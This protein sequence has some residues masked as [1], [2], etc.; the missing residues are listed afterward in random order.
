MTFHE[1]QFPTDIAFGST[2]GPGFSTDIVTAQSGYEQRNVNWATARASYNV[3]HGVKATAQ[4]TELIA[5]FRAR[6]G[7]AYGFRFKDWADFSV[8]SA[9]IGVGDAVTTQFQLVRSYVSGAQTVVRNVAKP[10]SG[11]VVIYLAGVSQANGWSV[12]TTT[13]IV[14]FLAAPNSGVAVTADFE[15]DVPVR[16][17]TDT[18]S[19]KLDSYGVNSWNNIPL[20]ELKI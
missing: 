18:L 11:T 9:A 16:F 17:D 19:A 20:V 14:T 2:G 7:K 12:D 8:T 15:F 13:G 4:L 3:A 1:V 5:F 10:V 6:Q